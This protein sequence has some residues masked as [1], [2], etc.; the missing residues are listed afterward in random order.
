MPKSRY[1]SVRSVKRLSRSSGERMQR[2]QIAVIVLTHVALLDPPVHIVAVGAVARGEVLAHGNEFRLGGRRR[3]AE[4]PCT[5]Y[6]AKPTGPPAE[7]H[8][9]GPTVPPAHPPLERFSS[10]R[11]VSGTVQ[12]GFYFHPS[13][14]DL[15]LGTPERKK[16][17][18]RC[19]YPLQQ[20]ENRYT[21]SPAKLFPAT[22]VLTARSGTGC[23]CGAWCMVTMIAA[24]GFLPARW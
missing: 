3:W 6:R 18:S 13:D 21:G 11:G 10:S 7:S 19:G 20:L 1:S 14:E 17:L 8:A 4:S 15:S 2:L 24:A 12:G 23:G 22:V 16:P 5:Q 9:A